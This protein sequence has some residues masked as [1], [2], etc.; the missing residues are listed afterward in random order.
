MSDEEFDL[1]T[2]YFV[3]PAEEEGFT[4]VRHRQVEE[5]GRREPLSGDACLF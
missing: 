2:R 4:V 1:F 5:G 3:P